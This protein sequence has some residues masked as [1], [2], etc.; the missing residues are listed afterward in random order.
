MPSITFIAHDSTATQVAAKPGLSL[1]Q[2]AVNHGVTGII[3]ECGGT[4]AC[5]TCHCYID[6]AWIDKV[7]PASSMEKDMLECV[8]DPAPNS[9]LGCQVK[10]TE[11]LD[12]LVVRLPVSQY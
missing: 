2:E 4:G 1:M 3:G 6:D 8:V 11:A 5:A 10:V 12:G 9:R 7:G